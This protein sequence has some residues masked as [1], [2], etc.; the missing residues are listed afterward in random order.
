MANALEVCQQKVGGVSPKHRIGVSRLR[1]NLTTVI[2]GVS[3]LVAVRRQISQPA[4][5]NAT[6]RRTVAYFLNCQFSLKNLFFG[7][8]WFI[9]CGFVGK[10]QAIVWAKVLC[11]TVVSYTLEQISGNNINVS[12]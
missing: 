7:D 5:A 11:R 6:V 1:T 4:D 2:D 8:S 3:V 12:V 10:R 9:F